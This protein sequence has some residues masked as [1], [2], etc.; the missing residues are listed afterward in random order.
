VEEQIT[1]VEQEL[2][3]LEGIDSTIAELRRTIDNITSDIEAINEQVS[4]LREKEERIRS[5][6][7]RRMQKYAAMMGKTAEQ[8]VYLQSVIDQFEIEQDDLLAGL[9][10]AAIVDTSKRDDYVKRLSDKVDGRSHSLDSIH[11]DLGDAFERAD[12]L[13]NAAILPD[14]PDDTSVMLPLVQELHERASGLRLRQSTTD[15]EFFNA[16]FRPFFEI[17]LYIEFNDRPLEALSMGERAIVL[18]KILLG[19]DDK[20]LLIDQPEEHLDNRYIYDELMPAFRSAKTRRQIIIATHNAN[21]VV[22][23]DAEQIIVA[24]HS[25]GTL[26]YQAGSLEDLNIRES[27]TTILEGGDQA[28]KKR[29]EKYGYHF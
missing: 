17:G 3:A 16:L 1:G 5:L 29:E 8:R 25:N 19:L 6:D 23:T 20:P 13:L 21:L 9:S 28:F 15:S 2:S 14:D 18:L 4:Q 26:S 27:I 10:F 12:E 11:D 22:N 7:L 24:E